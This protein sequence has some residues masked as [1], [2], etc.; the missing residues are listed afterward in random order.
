[1]DKIEEANKEIGLG[2]SMFLLQTKAITLVFLWLAILNTPVYIF[3]YKS[4][5][6]IPYNPSDYLM[7]LSLGNIG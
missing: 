3:F 4:N 1:M 6:S 5:E 2:A 7:K